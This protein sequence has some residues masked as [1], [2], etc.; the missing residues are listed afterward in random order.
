LEQF[1]TG[2]MTDR[3]AELH[4][5]TG[6]AMFDLNP[7][8]AHRLGVRPGDRVEV[9]SKYGTVIGQA[10]TTE[11]SRPG[12]I[13]A[14]F[15]DAKLLSIGPYPT[16][17]IRARKSPSTKT[18]VSVKGDGVN[19]DILQIV[20]VLGT[21]ACVLGVILC[22]RTAR[23]RFD[24][25]ESGNKEIN[26]GIARVSGAAFSRFLAFASLIVLPACAIF[27][28]NY[29]TFEGVHEVRGCASCHI[30]LRWPTIRNEERNTCGA[31]LREQTDCREPVLSLPRDYGLAGNLGQR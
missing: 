25:T 8:D 3:I 20:M 13:F 16:T 19:I 4:K 22:I 11:V 14:A 27:L 24:Q 29:H 5:T 2:T 17:M 18:A 12:V 26:L 1:H 9:K 28:A 15:Y 6:D 30:M 23:T 21:L 10:R 31:S 7:E